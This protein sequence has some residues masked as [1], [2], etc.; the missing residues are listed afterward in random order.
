MKSKRDSQITMIISPESIKKMSIQN[1][2]IFADFIR[3]QV[4]NHN[5]HDWKKQTPYQDKNGNIFIFAYDSIQRERKSDKL[6]KGGIRFEMNT[7]NVIGQGGG[8][9][10]T[11]SAG[12]VAIDDSDTV[13][14]KDKIRAIK[15]GNSSINVLPGVAKELIGKKNPVVMR[16][17]KGFAVAMRFI[18]GHDLLHYTVSPYLNFS[19]DE[20][21]ELTIALLNAFKRQISDKNIVHRD[22]KA[23]NIRVHF[24]NGK[25]N[26]YFIDF[27]NY[28][29]LGSI[30]YRNDIPFSLDYTPP[31]VA[32]YRLDECGQQKVD[33]IGHEKPV[34]QA[35]DIFSMGKVL[36]RL[37]RSELRAANQDIEDI[38]VLIE[39]MTHPDPN[40]RPNIDSCLSAIKR[41]DSTSIEDIESK[42]CKLHNAIYLKDEST[43][44]EL[45]N[46]LTYSL[47]MASDLP[48]QDKNQAKSGKIYLSRVYLPKEKKYAYDYIFRDLEGKIQEGRWLNEHIAEYELPKELNNPALLELI[49]NETSLSGHTFNINATDKRGR[50]ALHYAV[51]SGDTKIIETLLLK[52]AN[53]NILDSNN[54]VPIDYAINK[55]NGELLC[56]LLLKHG[57]AV[58]E[59]DLPKN[60]KEAIKSRRANQYDPPS[61]Y[62]Y[63]VIKKDVSV[64]L[65]ELFIKKGSD[66]NN[67]YYSSQDNKEGNSTILDKIFLEDI[68]RDKKLS[69]IN[70]LLDNHGTF[71]NLLDFP[72]NIDKEMEQLSF[73]IRDKNFIEKIKQH[74]NNKENAPI[75][76]KVVNLM[77]T[78]I[79]TNEVTYDGEDPNMMSYKIYMNKA[80]S[81]VKIDEQDTDL[82]IYRKFSR[83]TAQLPLHI[84]KIASL[85]GNDRQVNEQIDAHFFNML[86][87]AETLVN[88]VKI[89]EGEQLL[90]KTSLGDIKYNSYGIK[91]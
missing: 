6:E 40:K 15:I 81:L 31:E 20:K 22:I 72:N 4:I 89:L 67:L 47:K 24:S 64:K 32:I 56:E 61:S 8:G 19:V 34:S 54:R 30:A 69:I 12:T 11:T 70:L 48:N 55:K 23:D 28:R 41:P 76:P 80:L 85:K 16:T 44:K 65:L 68:P 5:I 38:R 37:W 88:L 18:K 60:S 46:K 49:L 58:N 82:E 62:L 63:E 83:F 2:K 84:Q 53:P 10:V 43:I 26:I 3:D 14:F 66:C 45:I 21:K 73:F 75:L 78:F 27:D 74:D 9:V 13:R 1:Q 33:Y 79:Q 77:R 86:L 90:Q 7:N 87:K 91:F 52:G 36:N 29:E 35:Q 59:F 57:A 17:K 50:T 25:F 71:K 51:E 42:R 39:N